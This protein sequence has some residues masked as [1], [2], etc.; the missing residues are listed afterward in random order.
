L[1]STIFGSNDLSGVI[2][3]EKADHLGP[4]ILNIETIYKSGGTLPDIFLRGCGLSDL[5]I[6]TAKLAAPGLDL[7][8]VTANTEEIRD[9]YLNDGI[10]S[11]SCFIS[12]N[13]KD[14][15]FAKRLHA[16]LQTNGVRAWLAPEDLKIGDK[17]RN[18]MQDAVRA[19]D[20]LLVVFSFNSIFSSWVEKEMKAVLEMEHNENQRILLPIC[21]D[22]EILSAE[23]PWAEEIRNTRPLGNFSDWKQLKEYQKGFERLFGELKLK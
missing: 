6:Q 16:D 19:V 17:F 9:Y 23:Q 15:E 5:Q 14:E 10:R 21:L 12:Y 3:L 1:Y 13:S 8:Q 2:D 4:S 20:K 18:H 7:E 22:D 11:Y